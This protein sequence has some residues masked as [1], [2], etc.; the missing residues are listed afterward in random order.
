MEEERS[1]VPEE[2]V[3]GKAVMMKKAG[4]WIHTRVSGAMTLGPRS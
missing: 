1:L 3:T 2:V 4:P